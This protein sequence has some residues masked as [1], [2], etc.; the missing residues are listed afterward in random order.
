MAAKATEGTALL[1]EDPAKS[2]GLT[3]SAAED[4]SARLLQWKVKGRNNKK[5]KS[6]MERLGLN[7]RMNWVVLTAILLFLGKGATPFVNDV[8]HATQTSL[9]DDSSL[10]ITESTIGQL[11]AASDLT[12][13][14]AK[15][16]VGP[17]LWLLGPRNAW[18]LVLSMGT[19][20]AALPAFT[21]SL[22]S[23]Y[24]LAITQYIFSAWAGPA[25]RE[26]V[27]RA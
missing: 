8:I 7:S 4:R 5:W 9:V 26:T 11:S 12:E 16:A 20:N 19:V 2:L 1:Q 15:L 22:W 25:T 27:T 13:G 10:N 21:R 18:L 23:L 3:G 14:L 6:N 17:A 24:N